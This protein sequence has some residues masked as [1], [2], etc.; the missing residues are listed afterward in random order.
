MTDDK[1]SAVS[2]GNFRNPLGLVFRMLVS[3]RRAAWSALFREAL[4]IAVKPVDAVLQF[5][6]RKVFTHLNAS[7]LP[8]MLIVGP[9]RCGTTLVYQVLSHCL[10]VSFPNNLSSLFP[11][12]PMTVNGLAG[13]ARADFESFYGQTAGMGGPNDAFH[14]WNR[15]LGDDRY[16]TRTDLS[17]HELKDM[18]QFFSAWSKKFGKPFLNKNNRN[19]HCIEQLAKAIPQAYFIGVSRDPI[20]VA[21]SLIR[22][23]ETVQGDKK[24]GWGLQCQEK[25]CH[26]DDLG[27]VQD[28]CDQVQRNDLELQTQLGGLDQDTVFWIQYESF[29]EN[30]NLIVDEIVSTIPQLKRRSDEFKLGIDAL[31]VSESE[32][33]SD[34]EEEILSRNFPRSEV[35][36]V[37]DQAV[38]SD[39][40]QISQ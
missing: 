36:A 4:S 9:P 11:K 33:L 8:L 20:C 34:E 37:S 27:Y 14:V 17:D 32:L 1:E 10:D 39:P 6:E 3:G 16:V 5:K 30:P 38:T 25:H 31:R 28:V 22:A 12:S 2:Y 7:N 29:C 40:F 26:E 15:W 18:R 19:V 35:V 13:N 24:I 23:R 21:R